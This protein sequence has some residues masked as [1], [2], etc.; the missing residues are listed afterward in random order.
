MRESFTSGTVGGALG[1][2]RIYPELSAECGLDRGN[3]QW[4]AILVL[5][6]QPKIP[7]SN[8]LVDLKVQATL[9][10]KNFPV[11]ILKK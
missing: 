10:E 5:F 4:R 2:Q 6:S 8:F 9:C 3:P 11:W 7:L 1:N